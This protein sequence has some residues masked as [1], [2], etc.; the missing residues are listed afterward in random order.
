[1]NI[2]QAKSR[3]DVLTAELNAHNHAYYVLNQ[4]SISDYEFDTLLRE[5]QD[6]EAAFPEMAAANSPTKRVGGDITDKFE[7]VK[8]RFPMLSLSNTYSQEEIID[9]ENRV[10]KSIQGEIEYVLE[11]KYDGVAI[12]MTYEDGVLVRAVTRGDG[13]VGEDVTTNVRTIRSVPLKLHGTGYPKSFDIRGEI[14]FPHAEFERLN[15]QRAD[16]G[17]E[18]YANP[19]NTASGTLKN[20]DSKL[21]ASRGLNCFLY[22][23]Y[24]EQLPFD[25]HFDSLM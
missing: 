18:L 14:Y 13:D 23:V 7:K 10:K 6:L 11:L 8:H 19:R 21:V 22:F 2:E 9:W 15:A 24:A 16:D 3:I 17:E 5:L 1:M 20:Q 12:S 25:N 4:P